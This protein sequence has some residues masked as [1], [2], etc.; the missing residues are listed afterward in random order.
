[1][2]ENVK[3]MRLR[4]RLRKIEIATREFG[5]RLGSGLFELRLIIS[6]FVIN[7]KDPHF[8]RLIH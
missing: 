7:R 5:L 8:Q 1:M 3:L 6:N 4:K 2:E